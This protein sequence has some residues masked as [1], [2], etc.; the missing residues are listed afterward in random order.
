VVGGQHQHADL[1]VA[2]A[3]GLGSQYAVHLGHFEIHQ[4]QVGAQRGDL[5][6]GFLAVVSQA[7]HLDI[8][9]GAED[10][11][12]PFADHGLVVANQDAEGSHEAASPYSSTM[13]VP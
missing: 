9:G 13:R 11:A 2:G 12:Q 10:G 8:V 7:D 1:G 3:H 4:D 5:V 6:E